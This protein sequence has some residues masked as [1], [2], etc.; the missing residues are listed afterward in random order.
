MVD[1][2]VD[3]GYRVNL[4]KQIYQGHTGTADETKALL[5][6][7]GIDFIVIDHLLHVKFEEEGLYLNEQFFDDNFQIVYNE[8]YTKVYT[9][10]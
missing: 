5:Y 4:M 3:T 9:A 1:S 2:S 6:E 8:D 7:E 10:Q